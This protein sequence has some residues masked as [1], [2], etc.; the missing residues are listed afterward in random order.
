MIADPAHVRTVGNLPESLGDNIIYPH[1]RTASRRL[2]QWVG[3]DN[4]TTAETE[5]ATARG[6]LNPGEELDVNSLSPLAQALIDAEAYLALSHGLPTFNMVMHDDT[7]VA[8]G[9][10]AGESSF[11]YLSPQEV[12]L[13]QQIYLRNAEEAAA[14]YIQQTKL[15][16]GSSPAYDDEGEEI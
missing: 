2:K 6:N 1:L 12:E 13:L 7:G 9:G 8:K 14:D 10:Q 11:Q 16:V 5:V 3:N 15:G 4:Y